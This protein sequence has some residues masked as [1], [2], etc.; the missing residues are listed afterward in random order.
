MRKALVLGGKA[1]RVENHQALGHGIHAKGEDHRGGAQIGN[2]KAV[3]EAHSCSAGDAKGYGDY[4]P[5]RLSKQS[6]SGRRHHAA[7]A[8]GPGDRQVDM[9]EENDEHH[10][11]GD[12][13]EK[14]GGLELLEKIVGRYEIRLGDGANG[15]QQDAAAEGNDRRFVEPLHHHRCH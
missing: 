11:R 6:C 1:A 8:N 7:D 3:D 12:D 15:D 5:H 10:A 4:R 2:A 9:A 14:R 13:A